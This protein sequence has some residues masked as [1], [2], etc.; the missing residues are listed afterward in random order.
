[1]K[2]KVKARKFKTGAMRDTDL[3]KEDYVECLSW[4]A[5]LRFGKYMKTQEKKYPPGNWR[6]GIPL[7]EYEKSLMRH[8]HKYFINKYENGTL[9]LDIDHLGA[10]MFNLQGI[11]HEQAKRDAKK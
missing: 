5:L 1:M 8:L 2:T 10:A 7:E 6:K 9:E 3:G 11:M 4:T